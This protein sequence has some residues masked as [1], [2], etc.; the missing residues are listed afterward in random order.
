M[1]DPDF[2]AELMELAPH[3]LVA[4]P[5]HNDEYGR[6]IVAS[7]QSAISV[8]C[9]IEGVSRLVRNVRGQEVVSSHF[10]YCLQFNNLSVDRHRY[11]LPSTFGPPREN[12][13]AIRVDPVSDEGGLLYE[14]VALP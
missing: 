10:A 1:A 2:L 6:F 13:E 14:I 3:E 4:T 9:Q 5:G 8:P 11:T 7:G 12:I